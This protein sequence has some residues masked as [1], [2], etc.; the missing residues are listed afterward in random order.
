MQNAIL[1]SKDFPYYIPSQMIGQEWALDD[2]AVIYT[3]GEWAKYKWSF[4][5]VSTDLIQGKTNQVKDLVDGIG[6]Q[7]EADLMASFPFLFSFR[8]VASKLKERLGKS[9]EGKSWLVRVSNA[10]W[11]IELAYNRRLARVLYKI[12]GQTRIEEAL[13]S[14]QSF[15]R[16]NGIMYGCSEE[17]FMEVCGTAYSIMLT[18]LTTPGVVKSEWTFAL[19]DLSYQSNEAGKDQIEFLVAVE[20]LVMSSKMIIAGD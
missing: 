16:R 3:A 15:I 19:A 17:D 8:H 14:S 10:Y 5:E 11:D 18:A 6:F 7:S 1:G 9:T 4:I 13:I 12:A 20:V 2:T